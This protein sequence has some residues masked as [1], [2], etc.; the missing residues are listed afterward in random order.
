MS[1]FQ[2]GMTYELIK[3]YML[4]KF[5]LKISFLYIAQVKRKCGLDVGQNY[6]LSKKENAK[7][8]Q[9]LL[10]KEVAIIGAWK[11]FGTI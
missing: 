8:P 4:E 6:N 10:E 5:E 7:V 2:K 1:E 3:V 11:Q 9:C